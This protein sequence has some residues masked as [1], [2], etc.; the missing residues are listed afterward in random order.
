MATLNPRPLDAPFPNWP[1]ALPLCHNDLLFNFVNKE[2]FNNDFF[3]PRISQPLYNDHRMGFF[4]FIKNNHVVETRS[5][6]IAKKFFKK[7]NF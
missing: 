2:S 6:M 7:S 4:G 3:Y 5:Y 1:N